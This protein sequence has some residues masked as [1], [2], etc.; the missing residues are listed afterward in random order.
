MRLIHGDCLEEMDKLIREGVTVDA[1]ITDPPYGTI[2]NLNLGNWSN[3]KTE[4]DNQINPVDIYARAEFL[5]RM[6]GK[7]ILFSQEPYTAKLITEASNNINFDYRMVWVKNNF[8][9]PFMSKKAPVSYFEDIVVFSKKHDRL[10]LHPLRSYSQKVLDFIGKTG[11]EI[12]DILGHRKAEH[13]LYRV[14]SSQFSICTEETYKE[15]IDNFKINNMPGFLNYNELSIINSTFNSTF[16]LPKGKS[17]KSNVLKYKK[18]STGLHPTQ[19]PVALMEDLILTYT[20]KDNTVLDFTMGSGTTGVACK[21]LNRD[22]IGIELDE[23]YY[24]T[25]CE[26]INGTPNGFD[27]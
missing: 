26:R 3:K 19:K 6:N 2:K 20:N 16:N 5:L 13:F 4:W 15:L 10:N 22:F 27:F 9:N 12:C 8:A 7:L 1:I 18:Y 25:A 11:K 14:N 17:Y 24:K 21:N 23:G